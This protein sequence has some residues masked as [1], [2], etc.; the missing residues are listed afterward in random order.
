MDKPISDPKW[1][2]VW[3]DLS[4]ATEWLELFEC[5]FGTEMSSKLLKWKYRDTDTIGIGLRKENKL[6]AFYGG[7]PRDIIFEQQL[8]HAVQMGDVMVHPSERGAFTSKGAFWSVAS[9]YIGTMVG[10]GKPY[11]IAFGFPNKRA[12]KLGHL[13]KLYE[14]VDSLTELSWPVRKRF[15][16]STW[17]F[18]D[19]KDTDID[20]VSRLWGQMVK[21][22]P[23]SALGV[24]DA[25]WL[26]TRYVNHPDL[27]YRIIIIHRAWKSRPEGILIF[28]DRGEDGLEL[29]DMI[30]DTAKIP[31]FI[32]MA[33]RY[34]Y[35][36]SSPKVFC[37]ITNSHLSYF[38]STHPVLH[39][40]DI[41]IPFNVLTQ[42]IK[43]KQIK[44][45]WWLMAG[46]T[47]F[48]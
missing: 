5:V 34:G 33:C 26:K 37:W 1:T 21:S 14:M 4:M 28:K 22:L 40:I 16:L 3:I 27:P 35:Q 13:L 46:D 11:E 9:N 32:E 30:G 15:P 29:I 20:H 23:E 19:W 43:T 48:R 39:D 44:N 18:H 2:P 47:D 31:M 36:R 42:G 24:R 8:V 6:V 17:S 38:E 41:V 12:Y 7:M 25:Q 10:E 45:R